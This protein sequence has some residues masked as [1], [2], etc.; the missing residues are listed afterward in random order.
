MQINIDKKT[1]I[2]SGIIVLLLLIIMSMGMSRNDDRGFFGM[3]GF[4]MMGSN[5]NNGS[6]NLS[7]ADVMFLQMMIPCKGL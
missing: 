4:G 5:H 6:P 3:H 2:L 1:G 7:G